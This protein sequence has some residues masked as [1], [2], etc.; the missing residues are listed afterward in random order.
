MGHTIVIEGLRSF[1]QFLV[2]KRDTTVIT[3]PIKIL[4]CHMGLIIY[5]I[6][7]YKG[8]YKG[9]LCVRCEFCLQLRS[10]EGLRLSVSE[11]AILKL[12][13]LYF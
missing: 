1:A 3:A 5:V 9:R 10:M 2:S 8:S 13:D 11:P 12:A 4:I 7:S 6:D